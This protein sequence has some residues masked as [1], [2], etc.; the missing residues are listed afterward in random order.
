MDN[1][2]NHVAMAFGYGN[3]DLSPF[4]VTNSNFDALL[5]EACYAPATPHHNL[6]QNR[7]RKLP[8]GAF[9]DTSP[10]FDDD[11]VPIGFGGSTS[12]LRE[13]REI[14]RV[15]ENGKTK[16]KSSTHFSPPSPAN[17]VDTS[18]VSSHPRIEPC[19]IPTVRHTSHSTTQHDFCC[20]VSDVTN[21][22]EGSTTAASN[23]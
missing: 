15:L 1:P 12:L 20:K 23:R 2:N 13:I 16:Y 5:L 6:T 19:E 18:P 4:T 8:C 10:D 17:Q 7:S 9:E 22:T 11:G 21:S 14:S 3:K